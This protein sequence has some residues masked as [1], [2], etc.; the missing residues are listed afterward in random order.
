MEKVTGIGGVF[1][2]AR[3]P[4]ALARWYRDHLGVAPVPESYDERPWRQ[5]AGPTVFG[6]FAHDTDYFGRAEQAWMI[7]FRVRDLATMVAQLEA[8]GIKVTVDPEQYPNGGLPGCTTRRGIRSSC[9]SRFNSACRRHAGVV[10]TGPSLARST[11]AARGIES[12]QHLREPCSP[13]TQRTSQLAP[14]RAP[15]GERHAHSPA[16][17]QRRAGPS[18]CGITGARPPGAAGGKGVLLVTR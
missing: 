1:F 2:R 3:D 17:L 9:G 12:Q 5:K 7:N 13:A 10:T 18:T 6:P 11:N 14:P 4:K 15:L 8:A 16:R